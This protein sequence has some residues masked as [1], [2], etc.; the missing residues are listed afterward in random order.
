MFL[1]GSFLSS[2]RDSL[3]L[4]I[5]LICVWSL[6]LIHNM[7]KRSYLKVISDNARIM[8]ISNSYNSSLGISSK[9]IGSL[10]LSNLALFIQ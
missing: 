10:S 9:L 7:R 2:S 6:A 4:E 1:V 3:T 5:L 8:L